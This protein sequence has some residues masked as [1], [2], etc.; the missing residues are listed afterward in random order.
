MGKVHPRI[1]R[2]PYK[3]LLI[4]LIFGAVGFFVGRVSNSR[5]NG[6]SLGYAETKK[7]KK[8]LQLVIWISFL[9]SDN[10]NNQIVQNCQIFQQE[11]Y[12]QYQS[13]F[14]RFYQMRASISERV[15]FGKSSIHCW[16]GFAKKPHKRGDMIIE[17][18]GEIIR[19]AVADNREREL[20]NDKV[21]GG[22][23]IFRMNVQKCVDATMTGNIAGLLN[24]SCDPNCYSK[25][26]SIKH[27][28]SEETE[29]HVLIVAKR[30]IAENEELTYD[31]RY[32]G[33]T[34][35]SC[36]CQSQGCRQVVNFLDR[37]HEVLAPRSQLVSAANEI[38]TSRIPLYEQ[39]NFYV[40][41]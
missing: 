22:T 26:I 27:A 11:E 37:E 20:Y 31:Y 18:V 38:D 36:N 24:H 3:L 9:S 19:H 25:T 5:I 32:A 39:F 4:C 8:C 23:Y 16:G 28:N 10:N 29:D 1:N 7:D 35:L 30:D 40:L 17:Y 33:E 34:S 41:D 13:S 12:Q 21:G 15:S 6:R 14:Q 2:F